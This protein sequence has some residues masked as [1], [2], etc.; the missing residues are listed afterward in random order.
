[1]RQSTGHERIKDLMYNIEYCV[2]CLWWYCEQL[3]DI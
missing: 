3:G 1:M 2:V